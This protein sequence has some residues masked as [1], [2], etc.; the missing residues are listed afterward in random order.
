MGS[1]RRAWVAS[2]LGAL[3]ISAVAVGPASGKLDVHGSAE[4]KALVANCLEQFGGADPETA[5][6]IKKLRDSKLPHTITQTNL[7]VNS[8]E[9]IIKSNGVLGAN[10]KPG[11]GTGSTVRW[12]PKNKKD[13]EDGV[14]RDPCASL[15]HELAHSLHFDT[16]SGDVSPYMGSDI[17]KEEINATREENRFRKKKGLPQRKKYDSV[18]LPS[19]AIFSRR[20]LPSGFPTAGASATPT[21]G[22]FQQG[23]TVTIGLRLTN[24]ARRAYSFTRLTMGSLHVV[25]ALRNGSP[26]P[27]HRTIVYTDGDLRDAAHQDL[28]RAAHG[29]SVRTAWQSEFD[30]AL[31]GEALEDVVVGGDGNNAV[32]SF[33]L[34]QPGRYTL[35]FFYRYPAEAPAGPAVFGPKIGPITVGFRVLP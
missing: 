26:T 33:S 13:F 28:R 14:A 8:S 12:N 10:G 30:S 20:L 31:G 5:D 18:D 22:P 11:R 7:D 29:Q 15:L 34:A 27:R 25:S 16:G 19:D 24:N 23:E 9:P 3:A 21:I 1:R 32:R 35:T 6:I 2:A 4:F 17:A